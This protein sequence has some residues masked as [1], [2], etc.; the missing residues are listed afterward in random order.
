MDAS[1]LP[2]CPLAG[3]AAATMRMCPGF[4]AASASP[5]DLPWGMGRMTGGAVAVTCAHLGAQPT[6]RGYASTCDHPTGRPTLDV[7]LVR[8]SRP[9]S[10]LLPAAG[11]QPA[12][13]AR[14]FLEQSDPGGADLMPQP[15]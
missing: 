3:R 1:L 15:A 11:P 14:P 4:V 2:R 10:S 5:I 13:T 6:S 9:L 12:P 7:E 8:R